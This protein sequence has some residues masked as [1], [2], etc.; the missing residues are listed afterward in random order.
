MEL[1]KSVAVL[2]Q[3]RLNSQRFPEKIIKKINNEL[4]FS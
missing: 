2:I 4:L 3:A 1:K